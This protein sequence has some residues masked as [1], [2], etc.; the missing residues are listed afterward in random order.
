MS[1]GT[2]ALTA[3]NGQGKGCITKQTQQWDA[4]SS[5]QRTS[6]QPEVGETAKLSQEEQHTWAQVFNV[7]AGDSQRHESLLDTTYPNDYPHALALV[8]EGEDLEDGEVQDVAT[9]CPQLHRGLVSA[10]Q[11][12][13]HALRPLNQGH[14]GGQ[15][16]GEVGQPTPYLPWGDSGW[17]RQRG[18]LVISGAMEWICSYTQVL[19][20]GSFLE[21][22]AY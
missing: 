9:R 21:S 8:S 11:R 12:Q 10:H 22:A 14:L 20:Y 1:Q 18:S 3:K 19:P 6:L 5:K 4:I 7:L 16:H 15:G 13:T 17:G 2:T